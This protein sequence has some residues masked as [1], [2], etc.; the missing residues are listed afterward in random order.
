MPVGRG[1]PRRGSSP[2]VRPRATR[3]APSLVAPG[4]C[5][6]KLAPFDRLAVRSRAT[7][8]ASWGANE[9]RNFSYGVRR[10][11]RFHDLTGQQRADPYV[12]PAGG[13]RPYSSKSRL[14]IASRG[15]RA[16]AA[17]VEGVL[18]AIRPSDADSASGVAAVSAGCNDAG[19]IEIPSRTARMNRGKGNG[20]DHNRYTG[21]QRCQRRS[22]ARTLVRH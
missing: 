5:T 10:G 14:T 21:R 15:R 8:R 3:R 20:H 11:V 16:T 22:A 17:P 2:T 19:I 18:S 9:P 6:C 12:G 13:S 4:G 1:R 7:S